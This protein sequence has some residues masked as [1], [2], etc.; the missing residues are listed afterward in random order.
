MGQR[1]AR[2][3]LGLGVQVARPQPRSTNQRT[4]QRIQ[5]SSDDADHTGRASSDAIS[6]SSSSAAGT[7]EPAGAGARARRPAA[8]GAR[9]VDRVSTNSVTQVVDEQRAG[10][11][12]AVVVCGVPAEHEQLLRARDGGVEQVALGSERVLAQPEAQPRGLGQGAPLLVGQ[13]RRLA[14]A[15]REQPLLQAAHEQR[16][17]S[18]RAQ[19]ERLEHGDRA[20]PGSVAAE[21]PH[22]L[23]RSRERGRV[24]GRELRGAPRQVRQL[25]QR[26]RAGPAARPPRRAR[27]R[28]APRRSPRAAGRRATAA[29]PGRARSAPPLL[30][31]RPRACGRPRPASSGAP[32]RRRAPP[33]R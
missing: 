30:A 14:R 9:S 2:A 22:S 23:E 27:R 10:A 26:P 6:S 1:P 16:A 28:P 29:R 32:P 24:R 15:T 25:G 5:A 12:R 19:G 13:Q 31:R 21:Q 8:R 4:G 18:A 33:S 11:R 20:R 17:D 7:S 3:R